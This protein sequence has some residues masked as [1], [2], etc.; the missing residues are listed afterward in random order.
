MKFF[1]FLIS[2]GL[3]SGYFGI[4]DVEQLYTLQKLFVPLEK[5]VPFNKVSCL[6]KK[7]EEQL[8]ILTLIKEH[9][10]SELNALK[11]NSFSCEY[12]TLKQLLDLFPVQI[13]RNLETLTQKYE[14]EF[15]E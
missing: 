4:N 1:D 5:I 3:D 10:F 7:D 13:V 9:S 11:T 12:K 14:I 15:P 8:K 2:S 6:L